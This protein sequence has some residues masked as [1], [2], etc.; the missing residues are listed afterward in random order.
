MSDNRNTERDRDTERE[1][2]ERERKAL[3]EGG[4]ERCKFPSFEVSYRS[5][6]QQV[7]KLFIQKFFSCTRGA[8]FRWPYV[9]HMH[10]TLENDTMSLPPVASHV[11]VFESDPF[12]S[13]GNISY[14]VL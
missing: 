2:G 12:F 6:R 7:L 8:H 4:G 1:M 11:Q 3:G 9:E 10:Q 14:V 13:V 5:L